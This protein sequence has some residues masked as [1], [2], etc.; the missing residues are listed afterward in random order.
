[1]LRISVI[2]SSDKAARLRL[3]GRL[4]GP[5]VGELR[6]SCESLLSRGGRL[7]LDLE[8]VSFIDREGITLLRSLNGIQVNLANASPFVAELLKN[9]TARPTRR[10][11]R[12]AT[13]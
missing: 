5:W 7:T 2:D 13:R 6:K 8:G 1:M 12:E 10:A 4:V 3:E 11:R 9:G